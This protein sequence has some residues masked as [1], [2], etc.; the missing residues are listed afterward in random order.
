MIPHEWSV[1]LAENHTLESHWQFLGKE[2]NISAYHN[3]TNVYHID[4]YNT[5]RTHDLSEE[6]IL[7][8][9]RSDPNVQVVSPNEAFSLDDFDDEPVNLVPRFRVSRRFFSFRHCSTADLSFQNESHSVNTTSRAYTPTYTQLDAPWPLVQISADQPYPFDENYY[10]MKNGGNG[11][12]VYVLDTGMDPGMMDFQQDRFKYGPVYVPEESTPEVSS[13]LRLSE[14]RPELTGYRIS[15]DTVHMSPGWL[16]A[17][18][19]VS[20]SFAMS[21]LSRSATV[22]E[23]SP[24]TEYTMLSTM[25]HG[26]TDPM[27]DNPAS[28]VL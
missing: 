26:N 22:L 23:Y 21:S 2:L 12:D 6:T 27:W 13:G 18:H 8:L 15:M 28:M 4:F 20:A 11:V 17:T 24:K 5:T 3:L 14:R 10:Y 25:S 1:S 16:A 7:D 9:I 19:T